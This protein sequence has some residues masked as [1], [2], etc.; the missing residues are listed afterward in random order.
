MIR[1]SF[2]AEGGEMN[3]T[4]LQESL[5]R[6]SVVDASRFIALTG[7]SESIGLLPSG[8]LIPGASWTSHKGQA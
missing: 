7:P 3:K 5:A 4:G 2:E 1:K 8:H 6:E